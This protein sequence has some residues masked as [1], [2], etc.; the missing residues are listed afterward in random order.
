MPM[1]IAVFDTV[2]TKLMIYDPG[3]VKKTKQKCE[4]C[5]IMSLY[6]AHLL[7]ALNATD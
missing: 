5:T 4:P 3:Q 7:Y 6:L 2:I 1:K